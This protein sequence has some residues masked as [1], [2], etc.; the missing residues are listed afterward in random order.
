MVGIKYSSALGQTVS[1]CVCVCVWVCVLGGGGVSHDLLM[2][3]LKNAM[4]A[5]NE[6]YLLALKNRSEGR[7]DNVDQ[8]L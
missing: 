3:A 5:E 8:V 4:T 2:N 7:R 1:V 6:D